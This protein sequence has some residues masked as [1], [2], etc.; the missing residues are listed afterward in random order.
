MD[1][2]NIFSPLSIDNLPP[3]TPQ[4]PSDF[5]EYMD[6]FETTVLQR[7]NPPAPT[8]D[9]SLFTNDEILHNLQSAVSKSSSN[10]PSS[11]T[12]PTDI[13]H[14]PSPSSSSQTTAQQPQQIVKTPSPI[15]QTSHQPSIT[16]SPAS[17]TTPDVEPLQQPTIATL[18]PPAISLPFPF[19]IYSTK[20]FTHCNN[21]IYM[22]NPPLPTISLPENHPP[23][24][25]TSH[26]RKTLLPTPDN[27]PENS[28]PTSNKL[29]HKS[30][31]SR[32]SPL[33]SKI[34]DNTDLRS[35]IDKI[36]LKNKPPSSPSTPPLCSINIFTVFQSPIQIPQ[37]FPYN[38]LQ[39]PRFSTLVKPEDLSKPETFK[40]ILISV[41]DFCLQQ[42]TLQDLKTF[43]Q[44]VAFLQPSIT[45][46][47][48]ST[49][50]H[51]LLC[52]PDALPFQHQEI[53]PPYFINKQ[54]KITMTATFIL[55]HFTH[56][57][58]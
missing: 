54:N 45:Y 21:V 53:I 31:S 24:L 26:Q 5:S 14:S 18:P 20:T 48:S 8:L 9:F 10:P 27:Q 6:Y 17:S 11:S 51:L 36:R 25:I 39:F 30:G 37:I 1:M 43:P 52:N 38:K 46:P 44:I 2:P 29:L 50:S 19:P 47:I 32:F 41:K 58:K 16:L 57:E 35:I 28:K 33:T 49:E 22:K 42:P 56:P 34:I 7:P 3:L 4:T 13:K 15:P 23:L 55:P 12:T 40:D